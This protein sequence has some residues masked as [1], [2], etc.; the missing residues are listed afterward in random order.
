[1]DPIEQ[2]E[3][4]RRFQDILYFFS[5]A[6]D[7]ELYDG[8]EYLVCRLLHK[9]ADTRPDWSKPIFRFDRMMMKRAMH[10]EVVAYCKDRWGKAYDSRYKD[11]M[12]KFWEY[13]VRLPDFCVRLGAKNLAAAAAN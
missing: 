4:E 2:L 11:R 3:T 5:I 8:M 10:R 6:T 1:M 9:T 12:D 7:E 13:I